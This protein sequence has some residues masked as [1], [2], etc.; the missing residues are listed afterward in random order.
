MKCGRLNA[1]QTTRCA[2]RCSSNGFDSGVDSLV[3]SD[4]SSPSTFSATELSAYKSNT[5]MYQVTMLPSWSLRGCYDWLIEHGFT[6]APTQYR[7]YGQRFLQV[8]WP[9]QQFQFKST[10]GGWLV[11]QTGLSLTRLTSPC[12][13]NTCR[14]YTRKQS[15]THKATQ[16]QWVNPAR[17]RQIW[18]TEPA[19]CSN[20]CA[21]TKSYTI[22]LLESSYGNT[23]SCS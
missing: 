7:L 14:Y 20:D 1:V 8:W 10:E 5:G 17:W 4:R 19:S 22:P 11:I 21:T 2:V 13:N 12:H 6:S 15:N 3:K 16:A 9:N 18:Q 23:P